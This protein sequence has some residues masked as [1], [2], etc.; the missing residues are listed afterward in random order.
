M[1]FGY[2]VFGGVRVCVVVV[3]AAACFMIG[4]LIHFDKNKIVADHC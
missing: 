3:A 4:L 2:I 1:L